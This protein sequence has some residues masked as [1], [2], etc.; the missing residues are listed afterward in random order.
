[1]SKQHYGLTL[2]V[3]FGTRILVFECLTPIWWKPRFV[4]TKDFT[5]IGWLLFAVDVMRS[6]EAREVSHE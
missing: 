6:L 5:C 3:W 1:V 2:F 4:H